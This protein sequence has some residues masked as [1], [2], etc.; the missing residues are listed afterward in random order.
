MMMVHPPSSRLL[1]YSSYALAPSQSRFDIQ[2][3]LFSDPFP[4]NIDTYEIWG[5]SS[6]ESSVPGYRDIGI[7]ICEAEVLAQCTENFDYHDLRRHFVSGTLTSE[8]LGM[9]IAYHLFGEEVKGD[10]SVGKYVERV[11]DTRTYGEVA[12]DVL[13]RWAFPLV[14]DLNE[15]GGTQYEL[16]KG[17]VYVAKDEVKLARYVYSLSHRACC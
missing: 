2:S 1:H 15:P 10:S 6:S 5:P 12:G 3:T 9:K 17:N 16:R 4:V 7:D 11:R 14:P 13:R 8:L